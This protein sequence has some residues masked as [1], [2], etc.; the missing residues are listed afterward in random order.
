[1]HTDISLMLSQSQGTRRTCLG[2]SCYIGLAKTHLQHILIATALNLVRLEA[3]LNDVPIGKTCIS[4]FKNYN[5][6]LL[7]NSQSPNIQVIH[8]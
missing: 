4:R 2:G 5:Q 7:N 8:R 3:W 1:M 6:S